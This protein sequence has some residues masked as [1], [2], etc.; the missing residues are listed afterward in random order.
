MKQPIA[1]GAR[2]CLLKDL[3]ALGYGLLL[4]SGAACAEPAWLHPSGRFQV[5]GLATQTAIHTTNNRFFG[6][7]DDNVG[8]E[9]REFGLNASWLAH[10]DLLLSAQ[11][12]Y[13]E[14]GETERD[15]RLQLDYA[16]AD[17]TAFSGDNYQIHFSLGRVKNPFGLFNETRDVAL[18]RSGIFLPQSI[19]PE[20][21]RKRMISGD[22]ISNEIQP[23]ESSFPGADPRARQPPAVA[24]AACGV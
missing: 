6:N 21:I 18:T 12:L 22:L 16:F 14:A 10:A 3:R 4:L 11:G 13:R 15:E 9:F 17:W 19:Y 20:R 8:F 2:A 5:H 24:G 23:Y 7:T 1:P